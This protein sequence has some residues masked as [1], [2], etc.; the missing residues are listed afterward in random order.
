M[1]P[2]LWKAIHGW[3]CPRITDLY[4]EMAAVLKPGAV[5]VECGVAYG[6]SLAYLASVL[7]PGVD[8]LAVDIWH[9]FQGR[10]TM[11]RKAFELAR[12][13]GSPMNEARRNVRAAIL[14]DFQDS[15][16]EAFERFERIEWVKAR[17][18]DVPLYLDFEVDFVF[19]DD[20]HEEESVYREIVAW[21]SK[22][23]SGGVIAGHDVNANYPGVERAVRR[24]FP[25]SAVVNGMPMALKIPDTVEIRNPSPGENG[26]GGVWIWRKP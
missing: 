7:D 21:L 3:T 19:L 5:A 8:I 18:E 17:S 13:S 15:A 20:H 16:R 14:K 11:P 25:N 24:A 4:D 9:T 22:L 10:T 26:W 1:K 12:S 23:K 6:K 2:E